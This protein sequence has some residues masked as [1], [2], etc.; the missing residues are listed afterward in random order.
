MPL[1]LY[2]VAVP[3]F[4]RNLR[5]LQKILEKGQA[6]SI[7]TDTRLVAD[8]LPLSFQVQVACDTAKFH[9]VRVG[10]IENVVMEDKE[11]TFPELIERISTTLK[12]LET[13]KPDSMDGKEDQFIVERKRKG[14]QVPLN[15]TQ[16][17]LE[18][19]LPNF[20]FHISMV[21]AILRK[22]GVEVGKNDYLGADLD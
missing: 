4:I 18:F 12:L 17:T 11:K 9:A 19:A 15:G 22:E 7:A 14:V 3:I 2:Q 5:V 6:R 20:F 16:Y 8:M 10:G 1:S 21:Y 13:V